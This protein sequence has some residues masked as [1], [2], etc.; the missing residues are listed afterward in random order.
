MGWIL[1]LASDPARAHNKRVRAARRRAKLHNR[2]VDVAQR[3][4]QRQ[5]VAVRTEKKA[6]A[7]STATLSG[8]ELLKLSESGVN[9]FNNLEGS[10]LTIVQAKLEKAIAEKYS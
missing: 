7:K 8:A 1:W 6:K 4:A 3:N 5:Q 2:N 9:V 10:Q